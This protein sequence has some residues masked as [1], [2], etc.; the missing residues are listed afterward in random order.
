M[1]VDRYFVVLSWNLLGKVVY[2]L[3]DRGDLDSERFCRDPSPE[4]FFG[5]RMLLED[6]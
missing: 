6:E 3:V 2:R 5:N 4:C 1:S